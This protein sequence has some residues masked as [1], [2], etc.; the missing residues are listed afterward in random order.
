[1]PLLTPLRYIEIPTKSARRKRISEPKKE[2]RN[3]ERRKHE[4]QN[5]QIASRTLSPLFR[6]FV[7]R[8]FVIQFGLWAQPALS[9]R[10]GCNNHDT[11]IVIGFTSAWIGCGTVFGFGWSRRTGTGFKS[12]TRPNMLMK[13]RM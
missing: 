5:W 8:A 2:S 4:K 10:L 11:S 7:F 13:L 3:P 12:H 6:V 9:A 1:M